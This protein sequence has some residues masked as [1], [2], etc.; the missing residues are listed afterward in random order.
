M[1]IRVAAK[2][3][4]SVE[5]R[6]IALFRRP[7]N[8]HTILQIAKRL[9][10][11]YPHVHSKV[12]ELTKRGVLSKTMVG[13]SHVCRIN[14]QS[15][16]AIALLTLSEVLARDA[17]IKKSRHAKKIS[18]LIQGLRQADIISTLQD[19]KVSVFHTGKIQNTTG[20][21]IQY[22]DAGHAEAS[23]KQLGE[24][25]AILTGFAKYFEM[26]RRAETR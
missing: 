26:Q 6:I 13:P 19:D 16:E 11:S 4:D 12:A 9:G 18:L 22:V 5:Q 14:L 8:S 3:K 15:D 23:L 1:Y 25:T 24:D 21:R 10:T 7:G 2:L 20:M 17:Q